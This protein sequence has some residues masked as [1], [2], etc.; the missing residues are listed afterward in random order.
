MAIR[1]DHPKYKEPQELFEVG[2]RFGELEIID[3]RESGR[4]RKSYLCKCSCGNTKVLGHSKLITRHNRIQRQS[5]GCKEYSHNG[6]LKTRSDKR[7]YNTWYEINKRCHDPRADNYD[8]YGG[9]GTKVAEEWRSDFSSFYKWAK[10]NGY[11][12]NLT[13]DRIDNNKSYSPDNC[14]WVDLYTQAQNKGILKNNK[15][16][17]TG[18]SKYKYG[19]KVNIMRNGIRLDLGTYKTLEEAKESR[20]G[21]EKYFKQHKTLKGYKT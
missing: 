15:T 5:C 21:A 3:I 8:R 7:I 1:S 17:V 12:D 6:I 18:V 2:T 19:Y 9:I 11:S 10:D 20:V 14:R 16:G 13:I 4:W